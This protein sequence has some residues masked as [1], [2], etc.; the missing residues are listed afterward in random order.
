L[1]YVIGKF[2]RSFKL[3]NSRANR[4]RGPPWLAVGN[5]SVAHFSDNQYLL[6]TGAA[7][8]HAVLALALKGFSPTPEFPE[9]AKAQTLL[10]ALTT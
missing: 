1:T 6:T 4:A 3:V 9:I 8:A 5:P 2:E 7:A 10:S